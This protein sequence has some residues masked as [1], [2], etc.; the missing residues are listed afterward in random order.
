MKKILFLLLLWALPVF[1][2]T[3]PAD[4][5]VLQAMDKITG[6]VKELSLS[7]GA[8]IGFGELTISVDRCLTKT[9]FGVDVFIKSGAIRNGRSRL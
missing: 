1:G 8:S 2:A 7:V 5:A 4:K 6:R 3:I 9:F